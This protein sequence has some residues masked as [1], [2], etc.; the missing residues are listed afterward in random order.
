ML[1]GKRDLWISSPTERSDFAASMLW[2]KNALGSV[3]HHFGLY[4]KLW[5]AICQ[6]VLDK[7]VIA[8]D[9]N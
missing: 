6:A 8:C 9:S 4:L 7:R 3:E 1:P 5:T 2:N